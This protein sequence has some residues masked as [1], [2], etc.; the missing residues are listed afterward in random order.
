ML[1]NIIGHQNIFKNILN[2]SN[3]S[4]QNDHKTFL[5]ITCNATCSCK[6]SSKRLPAVQLTCSNHSI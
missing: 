2:K 1:G 3:I 6:F 4:N 5:K